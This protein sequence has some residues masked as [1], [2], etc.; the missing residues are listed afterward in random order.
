MKPRKIYVLDSLQSP[1]SYKKIAKALI[2]YLNHM[3][4][5]R[6]LSGEEIEPANSFSAS[7]NINCLNAL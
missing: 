2:G 3:A 4:K 5:D 6:V 7:V 1:S